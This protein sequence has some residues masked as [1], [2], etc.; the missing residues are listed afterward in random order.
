M[1]SLWWFII[2]LLLI[3]ALFLGGVISWIIKSKQTFPR[4][5]MPG[6]TYKVDGQIHRVPYLPHKIYQSKQ[7][8]RID[9]PVPCLS[10]ENLVGLRKLMI[11]SFS[12]LDDMKLP[13]WVTGGTLLGQQLWGHQMCYDDDIDVSL[14]FR[15][16]NLIWHPDF[17]QKLDEQNLEAFVLRG[18]N[19]DWAPTRVMSALR[20]R[21]KGTEGPVMDL[22]FLD[23]D[24]AQKKWAHV[25]GWK[26]NAQGDEEVYYDQTTEV[27][28]KEW[29]FPLQRVESDGF[30]WSIPHE[31]RLMLD[32]HYGPEWSTMIKSPKALLRSHE[33]AFWISN[34][35]SAWKIL[36][37]EDHG[38][39]DFNGEPRVLPQEEDPQEEE[40]QEEEVEFDDLPALEDVSKPTYDSFHA[41]LYDTDDEKEDEK[42]DLVDE[43]DPDE[44][45]PEADPE[46]DE[47][48]PEADEQ[49]PDEQD[50]EEEE[51]QGDYM[52][53]P[54]YDPNAYQGDETYE[55]HSD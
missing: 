53:D 1:A 17:F 40:P 23:W 11:G 31:P 2:P 32:K 21:K 22:F 19:R 35:F 33:W 30:T 7:E 54:D 49:D 20:I 47:Q 25:N 52:F 42:E 6:E 38:I 13:Y 10:D 8:P 36:S 29:L 34:R 28:E 37:A 9:R 55:M 5:L 26:K 45:D 4:R 51:Y 14:L 48:D 12:V 18:V 27:W 41:S 24:P 46:A 39:P 15:H 44:Q 43:E 50:E 3:V 16:K